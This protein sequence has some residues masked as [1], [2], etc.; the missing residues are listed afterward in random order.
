MIVEL[1]GNY[2]NK[3]L[4]SISKLSLSQTLSIILKEFFNSLS[5]LTKYIQIQFNVEKLRKS[6]IKFPILTL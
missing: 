4:A 1:F 3:R 2:V 6:L 5:P